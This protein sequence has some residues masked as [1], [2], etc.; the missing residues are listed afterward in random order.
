MIAIADGGSTKVDWRIMSDGQDVHTFS[1]KGYNPF[2]WKSEAVAK[3]LLATLPEELDVDQLKEVYFYGS[4]CSDKSR[5][6]I[7][8]IAF[9]QVFPNAKIIVEHDLLASARATCGVHAGIACIL[10]T[11][12]NSCEYNGV[13]ITDNVTNLGFLLGDEGSGGDLGKRIVRSY[14]YREMPEE[15]RVKLRMHTPMAKS[16]VF[17]KLYVDKSPNVY[18]AKFSKFCSNNKEHAFIQQLAKDSFTEFIRRHILKYAGHKNYP[19]H[20]IGSVAFHFK[21]ILQEVLDEHDL[22]M[23]IIIKKPIDNLVRFH[24]GQEII[25]S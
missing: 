19:I 7:I 16:A 15:L 10:G 18:L 23:G 20:F 14:F 22:K 12:S 8:E 1:S 13:D 3:D 25:Q 6:E 24:L 9:Q 11:G 17:D 21:P 5:C 4:G 2:F